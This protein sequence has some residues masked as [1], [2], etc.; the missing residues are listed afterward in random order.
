MEKL[1]MVEE[2]ALDFARYL[3]ELNGQSISY[4]EVDAAN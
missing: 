1:G 2:A 4:N 3:H